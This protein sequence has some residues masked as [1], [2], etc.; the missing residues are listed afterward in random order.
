MDEESNIPT[1]QTFGSLQPPIRKPPTA[2]GT[3]A[4]LEPTPPAPQRA[5]Y[6]K[7]QAKFRPFTVLA[8]AIDNVLALI[9]KAVR[10]T[11]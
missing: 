8:D 5:P 1:T 11:R 2:I 4:P 10:P 6:M 7:A 3:D 9:R